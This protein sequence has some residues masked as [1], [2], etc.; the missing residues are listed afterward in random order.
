MV[1]VVVVVVS[2]VRRRIRIQKPLE[3]AKREAKWRAAWAMVA[4][5]WAGGRRSRVEIGSSGARSDSRWLKPERRK[6]SLRRGRMACG[7]TV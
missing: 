4:C 5:A 1:V 6:W 2:V 3:G 7:A